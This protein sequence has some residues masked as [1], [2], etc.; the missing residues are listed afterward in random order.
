[1]VERWQVLKSKEV[2]AAAPWIRVYREQVRLPDGRT[3]DDYHRIALT[4]SVIVFAEAADG[5]IIVERQYRHG[6]RVGSLVLPAGGIAVGEEPG[7]AARRELLEETGYRADHW[8]AIGSFV[9]HDNY[10]C[11]LAHMFA[12]SGAVHVAQPE[13]GD[14]ESIEVVLMDRAELQRRLI[15]GE[16]AVMGS[17]TCILLGLGWS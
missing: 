17:A 8:R 2:F 3:V 1:M 6:A 10:G 16:V 7:A 5:R 9:V 14:L 15:A 12:A 11:G 4:D 13:S